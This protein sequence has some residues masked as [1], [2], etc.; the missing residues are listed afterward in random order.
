MSKSK[1]RKQRERLIRE[2]RRNPLDD[3]GSY[4]LIDLRTRKTKTKTEKLNQQ[5]HKGRLSDLQHP[6]KRPLCV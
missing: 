3:R 1:A 6:D 5:K 4:T 2:G